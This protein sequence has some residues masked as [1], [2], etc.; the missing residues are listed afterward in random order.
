MD[1]WRRSI[2]ITANVLVLGALCLSMYMAALNPEHMLAE[3]SS[4]FFPLLAGILV[5][6]WLAG[7]LVRVFMGADADE[8]LRHLSVVLLPRVGHKLVRWTVISRP[9]DAALDKLRSSQTAASE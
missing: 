4:W 1:I 7:R 8:D 9:R 5:A 2:Q 6:A 3:L